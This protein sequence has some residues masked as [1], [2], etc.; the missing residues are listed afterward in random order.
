[1]FS[2]SERNNWIVSFVDRLQEDCIDQ[3]KVV[4]LEYYHRP[5]SV[6]EDAK[7][8]AGSVIATSTYAG[9]ERTYL[10]KVAIILG[11]K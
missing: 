3:E 6:P 10:T 8:L 4:D 9:I 5:I 11:A 2:V 7:P 1:M